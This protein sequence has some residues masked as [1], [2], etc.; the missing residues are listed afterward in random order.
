MPSQHPK[1]IGYGHVIE[2]YVTRMYGG[3][4]RYLV[5]NGGRFL[6]PRW[7]HTSRFTRHMI[8]DAAAVNDGE[9]EALLGYEWL[10]RLSSGTEP[11]E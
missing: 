6:G 4:P 2:R 8:A 10:S 5:L 1:E 11:R 9:L 3:L 7:G